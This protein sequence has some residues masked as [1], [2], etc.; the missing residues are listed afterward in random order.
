MTIREKFL[1]QTEDENESATYHVALC[2]FV[3]PALA[4]CT[5]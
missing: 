1:S 5:A 2:A 4:G 3:L